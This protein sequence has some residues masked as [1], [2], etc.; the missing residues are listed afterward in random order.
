MKS[1]KTI[2]D[3]RLT[4][5]V[6]LHKDRCHKL[7]FRRLLYRNV[8]DIHT[9]RRGNQQLA[10]RA[11]LVDKWLKAFRF[12][13][14]YSDVTKH[15]YFRV[16]SQYVRNAD[17][18]N[19][20]PESAEAVASWEKYLVLQVR[21]NKLGTNAARGKIST[22]KILLKLFGCPVE[23]W[24]SKFKLFRS[25]V[26]PTN[27]YS[28]RER[29]I[30]LELLL[31]LFNKLSKKILQ[32]PHI[33]LNAHRASPTIEYEF[34][35]KKVGI[36]AAISKCFY[37]AYFILA[38][39]TW[40]NDTT[41]R[42]LSLPQIQRSKDGNWYL[43]HIEKRR[44]KKF[45]D[46]QI[47]ENDSLTIPNHGLRFFE[48]LVNFSKTISP[49]N[50][51][52][53]KH[54]ING[55]FQSMTPYHITSFVNWLVENFELKDDRGAP[56]RARSQRFRATGSA[57]HLMKTDNLLE[58]A[59]L[60]GNSPDVVITNY[61]TGNPQENDR[62]IQATVHTLE[63]VVNCSDL[64][65]AKHQARIEMDI[66][67]LP[68]EAFIEQYADLS[69]Q[70]TAL[71]TGC[72]SPFD[73]NGRKFRKKAERL[74]ISDPSHLACADIL[75]CFYC[76][77]QVLIEEVDD[78]WCLMSFKE[79]LIDSQ[80]E[81]LSL[82]QFSRNFNDLLSRVDEAIFRVSPKIRR[83]AQKKLSHGRHP[84]WPEGFNFIF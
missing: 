11:D 82:S 45:I 84:G 46:V 51:Y 81:H 8:P 66:D 61:S 24:F 38:Y 69:P 16:L 23:N 36:C 15:S 67:V 4:L 2:E 56:L 27:A 43:A 40:A 78:V 63:A 39:Y 9:V 25:E 64:D 72:K 65:E 1:L 76:D 22:V 50:E 29:D 55:K 35:G 34:Q 47:G 17:Q 13:N 28:D 75:N 18:T 62:Q 20:H 32:A 14:D 31:D 52:L 71:G 37:A 70:T 10:N 54:C 12:A 60:L 74:K 73:K 33:H 30:L 80:H 68:Y 57:A 79:S 7:F 83:M 41:L 49:G 19:C 44:A 6:Q 42:N 48:N 5:P 21:L 26:N 77:N 3:E 58:T 59:I 53:L